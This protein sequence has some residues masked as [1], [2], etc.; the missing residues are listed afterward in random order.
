MRGTFSTL[1]FSIHLEYIT[2]VKKG[3]NLPLFNTGINSIGMADWTVKLS[4]KEKR[5]A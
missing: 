1:K 3:G 2:R 5:K 4:T